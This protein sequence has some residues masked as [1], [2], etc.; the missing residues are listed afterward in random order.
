MEVNDAPNPMNANINMNTPLNINEPI[1]SKEYEL[2]L[3]KDT[4]LLKIEISGKD[5]ISFNLR[6]INNISFDYFYQEYDYE[7][8]VKELLI[9]AQYYNNIE[10]VYK[11]YDTAIEKQKVVLAFDKD[12]KAMILLL[13]ITIFFDDIESKLYLK[14]Y[15]LTNE[16]MIKILFNEI[17]YIKNNKLLLQKNPLENNNNNKDVIN[18]LIV[19]NEEIEKEI[20]ENKSKINEL[21]DENKKIKENL[22]KCLKYI[23]SKINKKKEEEE[24][25]KKIKEENNKYIK[26]NI[27]V[28]FKENPK[29]LKFRETLTSN[30]THNHMLSKF[31]VYISLQ[32]HIEYLIY[33]N[34]NNNNLDIMRIRD[35]T[36]ITSLKGHET[37]IHAIKYYLK[38]HKEDYILSTDANKIVIIWDIQNFYNKKYI[39]KTQYSNT[40]YDAL[41]LF[42]IFNKDYI[43]LSN[44]SKDEYCKLYEFKE[45]TPFI[46]NIHGTNDHRAYF[47]IPWLYQNKYYLI[48]CSDNKIYINNIFEDE[49]YADLSMDPEGSYYG[50]YLYNDNYLCVSCAGRYF[51]RIWD[52]A[53]KVIF[54]QI[55]FENS[56]NTCFYET[57]FWNNDFTIFTSDDSI[58]MIDIKESKMIKKISKSGCRASAKKIKME[59]LGECLICKTSSNEIQLYSL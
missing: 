38:D 50:G 25:N 12:K 39:I 52:L 3:N 36:V 43:L 57:I 1:C 4:Y 40:I 48:E 14:E 37:Y 18:Q 29:N 46:R 6:Q 53:K 20:K 11:F 17:K 54:K 16:E 45:N 24:I 5:K 56:G 55:N 9:P 44:S 49:N 42:N 22:D 7:T 33:G 34:K 32:D 31:D 28:E 58:I 51:I 26:E 21:I 10:K 47:I 41:L 19:K 30:N 2:N 23:E 35:K 15:H 13:K 8:L 59:Q 27:K